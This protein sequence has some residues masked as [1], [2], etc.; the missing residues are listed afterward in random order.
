MWRDPRLVIGVALVAVSVLVGGV[1]LGG[2]DKSV[3]VWTVRSAMSKGQPVRPDDLVRTDVQ[4]SD[5]ASADHYVSADRALPTGSTL[6]RDVGAGEFLPRAALVGSAIGSVTE[7]PLSVDTGAVPATVGAGSVVD[8]WVTPDPDAAGSASR[9]SP[10]RSTLVFDDVT[11]VSAPR[12]GTSLGPTSTRQVIIGLPSG[13][14]TDLPAA[15]TALSGGSIL[16]TR[17]R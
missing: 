10:S 3:A 6:A 8:V 1:V 11:V 17:Q 14:E 2:A 16:I 9:P 13:K 5:S 7:V 15:L 4:F 12:S